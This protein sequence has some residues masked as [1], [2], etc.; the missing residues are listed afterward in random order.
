MRARMW[1]GHAMDEPMTDQIEARGERFTIGRAVR[2]DLPALAALLADDVLGRER[3]APDLAPYL[4]AFEAIDAD[5]RHFLAAIRDGAGPIVGTFQLS[6]VPGLSRG[7]ATRLQI[8]AVRLAPS[9]RGK[10]LGSVM[11]AWA[12]DYGRRRG[13]TLAQLT[14]DRQRTE[15]QRF[16]EQLGY[17]ASHAGYKRV[18]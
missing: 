8:E 6:L 2:E 4:A 16:Y 11:L 18:L 9:T 1:K 10:G 5:P 13:A 17:T 14:T 15:A 12:H 3:E 7:G